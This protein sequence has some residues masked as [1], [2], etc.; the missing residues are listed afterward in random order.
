MKKAILSLSL[1]LGTIAY[2]QTVLLDEGFETYPNFAITGFGSWL[3]LDLDGAGTFYGGGP[4]IG[5]TT[6]P[7]WTPNWANASSPKSFQIFNPSASNATNNLTSTP[8]VDEEIR[9]FTPHGGQKYAAAWAASSQLGTIANNDWLI[10]PAVTLGPN[11]N[12]L[13]FWVKAL[14]PDYLENYKVGVYTG[15][16]TPTSGTNFT[17]ISGTAA[18]TATYPAW[19]QVTYNLDSYSGQTIR[20]GF[21]YMSEDKYMLMLDDVKVTT[22]GTLATNEASK[23]KSS[24]AIYPNPTRGEIN[25][26]TDK[27]VKSI[28]I[29][30]ISGKILKKT[31]SGKTDITSLPKGAYLMQ[32]EFSDGTSITEKIIKQ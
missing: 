23:A 27:K 31:E 16:G 3:T 14:S 22:S 4:V 1:L 32:V 28:S 20:I 6:S 29:I 25:I 5:G 26:K 18:L 2:S 13:T 30:D 17:I 10:S 12:S 19:Q 15:T 24:T 9:D 11:S 21:H 8:G 7:T